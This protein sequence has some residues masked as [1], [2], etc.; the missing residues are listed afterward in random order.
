MLETGWGCS[1]FWLVWVS[2][3]LRF[4]GVLRVRVMVVRPSRRTGNISGAIF[5]FGARLVIA[6]VYA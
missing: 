3:G 1:G 6:P 4:G 2:S 5:V